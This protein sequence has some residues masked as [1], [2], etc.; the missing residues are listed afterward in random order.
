MLRLNIHM[1]LML[2]G[3]LS[4]AWLSLGMIAKSR[5]DAGTDEGDRTSKL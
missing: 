1:H 3:A 4:V 2:R 5:C